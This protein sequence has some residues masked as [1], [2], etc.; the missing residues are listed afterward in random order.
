[1]VIPPIKPHPNYRRGPDGRGPWCPFCKEVRL[2]A[3]G[4]R[5]WGHTGWLCRNCGWTSPI[6]EGDE[7][8]G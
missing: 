4:S 7:K 8:H 2:T 1:M 3:T 6:G 5:L